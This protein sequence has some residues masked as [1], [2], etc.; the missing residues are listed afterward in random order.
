MAWVIGIA[1]FLLL[2]FLFPRAMGGLILVCGIAI[3]GWLLSD[4]LEH[5]KRARERAAVS[6]TVTHDIERCQHTQ[7]GA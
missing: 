2:L 4:K 1:V 5:D 6:L 7:P 3:G